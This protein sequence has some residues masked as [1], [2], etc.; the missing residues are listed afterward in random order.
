MKSIGKVE[1]VPIPPKYQPKG[2][3]ALA[4]L[5]MKNGESRLI[6]GHSRSN[7][8]NVAYR[9]GLVLKIMTEGE[10]FRVWRRA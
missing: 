4:I 1:R 9:Y 7:L 5:D 2:P 8:Y 10:G 6:I 3:L